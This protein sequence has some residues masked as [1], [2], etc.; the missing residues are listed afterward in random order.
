METIPA[1]L[2]DAY[3]HENSHFIQSGRLQNSS[4]NSIF[5][6]S[7]N[8]LKFFQLNTTDA[9]RFKEQLDKSVS[10]PSVYMFKIIFLADHRRY[11]LV[12]S[13][14]PD[15]ARFFEKQSSKGKY[16]SITV[17]EVMLN[18]DEVVKRYQEISEIEGVLLL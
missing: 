15:E 6:H 5:R 7:H 3:P 2:T 18:A 8:L 11:A 1:R 13:K 9:Q 17:K 10:W 14:F 4:G 12:R 16:I